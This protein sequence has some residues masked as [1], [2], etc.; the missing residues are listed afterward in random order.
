MFS[1]LEKLANISK[2]IGEDSKLIQASGGNTSL[3]INNKLWIKASGKRLKNACTEDIF[4]CV[5]LDSARDLNSLKLDSGNLKYFGKKD[6]FLKAS[7]ETSM[8]AIIDKK[9]VIHTH[10]VDIISQTLSVEGQ[11]NIAQKLSFY[12]YCSIKYVKPG[13]D[14]ALKIKNIQKNNYFEILILHNHGLVIAQNNFESAINLQN[15]VISLLKVKERSYKKSNKK[16]LKNLLSLFESSTLPTDEVIHSLA[17]DRINYRLVK[18][19][20]AYPDHVVFCGFKAITIDIDKLDELIINKDFRN[21]FNGRNYLIIE[22]VGVLVLNYSESLNEM[23]KCQA[24]VLLR[25]SNS[26]ELS[27]L[28]NEDCKELMEWDAEKYRISMEKQN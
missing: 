28:K 13:I 8:H 9:V 19:N 21:T 14:L 11:K 10:P 25:I 7:I 18:N 27:L 4:T 3:K 2:V 5:D 20:P 16:L 24:E 23:L 17:T 1:E 6:S 22:D 26:S 15:K 12:N